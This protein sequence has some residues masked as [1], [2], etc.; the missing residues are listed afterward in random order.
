MMV[1]I[2]GDSFA[3][4]CPGFK[5]LI[6]GTLILNTYGVECSLVCG[7]QNTENDNYNKQQQRVFPETGFW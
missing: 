2:N 5:I 7:A 4:I 6:W 1:V 3:F